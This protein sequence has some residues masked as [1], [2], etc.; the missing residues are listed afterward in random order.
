ML[1][2]K[3]EKGAFGTEEYTDWIVKQRIIFSINPIKSNIVKLKYLVIQFLSL[4]VRFFFLQ[5]VKRFAVYTTVFEA[6]QNTLALALL[7]L[8]LMPM[9]LFSKHDV[10]GHN[11]VSRCDHSGHLDWNSNLLVQQK[12]KMP[13]EL[14]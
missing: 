7:M 14:R 11:S 4:Y 8:M 2:V 12:K 3:G 5:L 13:Q 10:H 1:R 9:Y 6:E